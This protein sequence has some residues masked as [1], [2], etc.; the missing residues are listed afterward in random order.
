MKISRKSIY[1]VRAMIEIALR[2][3]EGVAAWQQISSIAKTTVIPDK[4]LEQIL[5]TLKKNGLLKSRRGVDGGYALNVPAQEITLEQLVMTLDSQMSPEEEIE[6]GPDGSGLVFRQ[7]I[8][9]AE[10]AAVE[11]L[12][13]KTLHDLV[14]ETRNW[15][16]K[17]D[18]GMEFMI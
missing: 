13:G 4:F 6:T 15:R 18:P 1:G 11:V 8:Q 5:L 7:L 3:E 10:D 9:S 14:V 17:N 2:T 12:R 16:Q